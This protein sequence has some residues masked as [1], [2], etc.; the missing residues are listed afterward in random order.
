MPTTT[1][2]I[3]D[4]TLQDASD[5]QTT[6]TIRVPPGEFDRALERADEA[7]RF[8]LQDGVTYTTT[9]ENP[10]RSDCVISGPTDENGE[11]TATIRYKGAG[12]HFILRGSV[13]GDFAIENVVVDYGEEWEGSAGF[14]IKAGGDILVDN[15]RFKG[16]N[17]TDGDGAADNLAV[18]ATSPDGTVILRR[19][20]RTGPTNIVSHGHLDGDANEGCIWLGSKHQGDLYVVDSVFANCGTN[21]IYCSRTR[22]STHFIRTRFENNNQASIR[23]G[24]GQRPATVRDCEFVIDTD[25]AHPDNR[26][27]FINPHGPV[28]ETKN[29][30][31]GVSSVPVTISNTEFLLLSAPEKSRLAFADG[32]VGPVTIENSRL[33]SEVEACRPFDALTN[34]RWGTE[35]DDQSIT[36][37]NCS[38]SGAGTA[39]VHGGRSVT[40]DGGCFSCPTSGIDT[41]TAAGSGCQRPQLDEET[42]A[43]DESTRP[44][45]KSLVVTG[46]GTKTQYRIITTD[47]IWPTDDVEQWDTIKDGT[48]T[49]WITDK[50]DTDTYDIAGDVES[51]ELLQGD[52][53]VTVEGDPVDD[54]SDGERDV[55]AD[56]KTLELTFKTTV[57]Y[58]FAVDGSIHDHPKSADV[59]EEGGQTYVHGYAQSGWSPVFKV[60]G[61]SFPL[62][63]LPDDTE[64]L[65]DGE[66]Y[67]PAD[68]RGHNK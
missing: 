53:E 24:G 54:S 28:L 20:E 32:N 5:V 65:I 29:T 37:R 51:V 21:A 40:V 14:L 1:E 12:T 6:R 46:T 39:R 23:L 26:G 7:T 63:N 34:A 60:T 56:A 57:E 38:F 45:T 43:P 13:S 17:P 10:P 41:G 30:K 25:N 68:L 62:V 67:T 9:R 15:V 47:D 3:P 42:T 33:R 49:A 18:M 19:I 16:F 48:I 50:G 27:E 59:Y 64:I 36:F 58:G 8:E 52:A 22:G 4:G 2:E 35:P 61:A 11:P 44:S 66:A 55:P 31:E